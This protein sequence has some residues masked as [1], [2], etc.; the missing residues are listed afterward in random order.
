MNRQVLPA[1][2]I[3]CLLLPMVTACACAAPPAGGTVTAGLEG[4]SASPGETPLS[5]FPDITFPARTPAALDWYERGFALT[6]DE[7][8]REAVDAYEEALAANRSLLNA[9]YYL[10]DALFRL[11]RPREALLALENATAIDPDFVDAYFYES[12]IFGELGLPDEEKDALRKGLEAAD[13][14]TAENKSPSPRAATGPLP[15]PLPAGTALLAT[16][17]AAACLAARHRKKGL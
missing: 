3:A 2:L 5:L 4:G 7:R 14:R 13:R 1:A 11:G 15:Q 6:T 9:W 17:I 8:Y 16:G 10:G 12:R